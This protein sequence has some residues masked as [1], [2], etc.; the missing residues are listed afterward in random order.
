MAPT[1]A[2]PK[3]L[4]MHQNAH[5]NIHGNMSTQC[6]YVARKDKIFIYAQDTH[7]AHI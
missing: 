7:T 1:S 5:I 2:P 6:M 4:P 3:L